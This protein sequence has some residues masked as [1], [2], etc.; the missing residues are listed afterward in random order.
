MLL[1][2]RQFLFRCNASNGKGSSKESDRQ[3][4]RS[5]VLNTVSDDRQIPFGPRH[6]IKMFDW[7]LRF[8][9]GFPHADELADVGG[10]AFGVDAG[11]VCF[12]GFCRDSYFSRDGSAGFASDDTFE[13]S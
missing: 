7:S 5:A 4:W 9:P 12:D 13:N 1:T 6:R 11:A 8:L 3:E 2:C 10:S